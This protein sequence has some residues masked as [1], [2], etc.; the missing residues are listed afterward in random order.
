MR[1]MVQKTWFHGEITTQE[2]NQKLST[3]PAGTFLVRFSSTHNGSYTISSLPQSGGKV[4]HQ[5]VSYVEGVGYTLNGETKP[6]LEVMVRD[7][8][9]LLI[10]CPGSKYQSL[11]VEQSTEMM[12]YE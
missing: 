2:A 6:S 3:L 11:F 9:D 10:P 1:E 12:G 7:A 5:R 4:K 8:N